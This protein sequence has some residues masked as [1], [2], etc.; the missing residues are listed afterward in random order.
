MRKLLFLILSTLSVLW[1]GAQNPPKV[2]VSVSQDTIMIGDQITMEVQIHKDLAQEVRVPEFKDGKLTEK[3][4]VIGTPLL[5]TL[6]Q[7]GRSIKMRL[8]YT[9]TSFDAGDY[10]MAGFP[11][12][13][14]VDPKF[15][16]ILAQS[17]AI[18]HVKTFEIDT[19]K[20][21]I[22][23]IKRPLDAPVTWAEIEPYFW[24]GMLGLVVLVA[25]IWGVIWYVRRRKALIE[26]RPKDPVH[27]I[28]L[29]ELE[30][31]HNRKLW[32]AGKNK[33]YFSDLTDIVRKYIE[34]RFGVDAMEMTSA[35]IINAAKG[36]NSEKLI[37]TLNNL[38]TLADFVKFA[39]LTPDGTECET[40]YF[41][42]YYYVEQTKEIIEEQ[43]TDEKNA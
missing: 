30:K 7:E 38:F 14:G 20:Q 6:S 17:E 36:L 24:W 11:I 13:V 23:D 5:D 35:E 19:T 42:A 10:Q 9:I 37:D 4:E 18:L 41:D 33:E 21:Q 27:V 43:Q 1:V 39:K 16:T 15:D 28:A 2:T 12:V 32:Q 26:A 8:R 34:E 3:L 25:I 40:A 22:Y 29:K 31:L